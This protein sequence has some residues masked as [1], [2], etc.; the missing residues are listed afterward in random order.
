MSQPL[1]SIMLLLCNAIEYLDG[2]VAFAPRMAS[3]NIKENYD[4]VDEGGNDILTTTKVTLMTPYLDTFLGYI[5]E[6][7]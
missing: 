5:L 2:D 6:K 7:H 4:F 3:Q 1:D